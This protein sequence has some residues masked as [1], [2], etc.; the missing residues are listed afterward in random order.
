V[1]ELGADRG[2]QMM[3]D[4]A[5]RHPTGVERD[6]HVVETAQAPRALRD[7][8]RAEAAVAIAW[9]RQADIADLTGDRLGRESIAGVR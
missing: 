4:T 5:D 9:D 3:L 6:D 8:R 7:Q 2:G 1:R